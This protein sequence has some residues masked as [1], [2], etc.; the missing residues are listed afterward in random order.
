MPLDSYLANWDPTFVKIGGTSGKKFDTGDT[1]KGKI[2]ATGF[3]NLQEKLYKVPLGDWAKNP[4][5]REA[6]KFNRL[7]ILDAM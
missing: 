6:G 5:L 7:H 1:M 3:E 4:V 2:E